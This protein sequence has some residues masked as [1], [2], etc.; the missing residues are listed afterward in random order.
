MEDPDDTTMVYG[1]D[2]GLNE[3]GVATVLFQSPI[4]NAGQTQVR[5]EEDGTIP[6]PKGRQLG[7]GQGCYLTASVNML[8]ASNLQK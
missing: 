1:D 7:N 4:E 2:F 6:F 8:A 5:Q 3:A